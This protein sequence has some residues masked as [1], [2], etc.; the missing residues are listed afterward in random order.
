MDVLSVSSQLL[1]RKVL[2]AERF[3]K[4]G[5]DV[6]SGA[7]VPERSAGLRGRERVELAGFGLLAER[8]KENL[9]VVVEGQ[10]GTLDL[11]ESRGL[12]RRFW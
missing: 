6:V 11:N 8:K 7:R 4:W 2:L 1:E 10:N 5:D 3:W 9:L 12:L